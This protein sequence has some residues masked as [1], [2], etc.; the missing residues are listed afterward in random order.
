[1]V[2]LTYF[3]QL[4]FFSIMLDDNYED[5]SAIYKAILF[6][7]AEVLKLQKIVDG[8]LDNIQIHFFNNK[9]FTS[10]YQR[11]TYLS[12]DAMVKMLAASTMEG[13]KEQIQKLKNSL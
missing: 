6:H 4:D 11:D 3:L 5:F 10:I 2:L 7:E 12:L 9:V 8:D 1:M 13:Y